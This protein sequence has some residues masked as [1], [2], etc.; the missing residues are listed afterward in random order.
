[1]GLAPKPKG[2]PFEVFSSRDMESAFRNIWT[3]N[4][5]IL[6]LLYTGTP[7]LKT[8]FTRTGKR[9]MKG[10]LDDGKHSMIRYYINNFDDG[11]NHDCLD[12]SQGRL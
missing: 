7:A 5:D 6:S 4:A 8:D 1:M 3:D 11:Y 9:S 2:E 10:A 12:I